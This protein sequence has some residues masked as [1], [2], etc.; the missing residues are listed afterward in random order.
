M[1]L[2]QLVLGVIG[3]GA[4]GEALTRGILD[5]GLLQAKQIIIY[6]VRR[7]HMETI[8]RHLGVRAAADLPAVAA[9][10]DVVL[11]AVKPQ[12]M[13]DVL[14]GLRGHVRR[15][16]VIVSIAAGVT[17]TRIESDLGPDVPVIRV[18]PNTPALVGKGVCVVS[19]GA[20]ATESE[21]A[22][23]RALLGSVGSVFELP[24][25]QMDTVTG[26]SGSG[27][28]YVCLVIEALADGAVE[29]GLPRDVALHLAAA[30]VAGAGEWIAQGLA[31]GDH[32]AVLRERVTS[33]AGTTAA[34]LAVLEAAAA[35]SAFAR[36][37][38]AAS[39]RSKELGEA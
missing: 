31:R 17:T 34:G 7:D 18:M 15:T 23:V 10:A 14:S 8:A 9:A 36:A 4:M 32:P 3:V 11:L 19:P 28:A 35:R 37:V 1:D 29:D 22:I 26:L 24:E 5:R 38:R 2:K 30:T 21:V 33:P 13:A 27:P 25:A 39:A 6:D 12:Q 16:Q 20:T